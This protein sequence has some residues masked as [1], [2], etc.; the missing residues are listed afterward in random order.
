MKLRIINCP[1]KTRFSPY[2]KRAANFYAKQLMSPKM[3]DNISICIKFNKDIDAFGYASVEDY[4][5]WGKPREFEIEMHPGIGAYDILKTLAHE[6]V[7][8]KQYVYGET[9]EAMTR[10][11]GRRVDSEKIDYW[12]QPW[13][14]EA[15]GLEI[16]L[17]TLFAIE[18]KLWD[19][20]KGISNPD[21]GIKMEELG[22]KDPV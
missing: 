21:A 16:G 7:H 14:V 12:S 13:E 2:I 9:N 11:K 10:W 1:D 20:F 18:E 17:F 4:N 5:D 8:V 19:V 22:W 6:M 3:L 15:H